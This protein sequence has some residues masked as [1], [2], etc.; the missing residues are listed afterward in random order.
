LRKR[1]GYF[2]NAWYYI[3]MNT[4]TIKLYDILVDKGV[5]KD[6]AREA[7]DEFLTKEEARLTLVTK[8]DM[9]LQTM[10]I[11]GMLIGQVAIISG[12]VALLIGNIS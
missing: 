6:I 12:V 7:L 10:W 11:A 2:K 9:R 5:S 3:Y 1:Y 4:A 8:E